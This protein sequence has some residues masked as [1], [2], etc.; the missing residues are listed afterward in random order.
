MPTANYQF[1]Q[2]EE[3]NSKGIIVGDE[4]IREGIVISIGKEVENIKK[5]D[6]VIFYKE[7]S[8]HYMIE[9][10]MYWFVNYKNI[11]FVL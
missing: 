10:K 8:F 11:L 3:K 9:G 6:K 1:C 4:H 2:I 5:K 7:G